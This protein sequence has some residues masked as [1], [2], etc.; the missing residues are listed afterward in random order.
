MLIEGGVQ[1]GPLPYTVDTALASHCWRFAPNPQL[2][3]TPY[4]IAVLEHSSGGAQGFPNLSVSEWRKPR[5]C[6]SSCV[7]RLFAHETGE[8]FLLTTTSTSV[9]MN[10]VPD[11]SGSAAEPD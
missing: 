3:A 8:K 2:T 4:M 10:A 1:G 9:G 11:P 5:V 6:P 7:M